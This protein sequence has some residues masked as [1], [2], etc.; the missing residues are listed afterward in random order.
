ML[1]GTSH[2]RGQRGWGKCFPAAVTQPQMKYSL[3][4]W[5]RQVWCSTLVLQKKGQLVISHKTPGKFHVTLLE[6]LLLCVV[7]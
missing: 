4:F 1:H 2:Y 7:F 5:K 3:C 6:S